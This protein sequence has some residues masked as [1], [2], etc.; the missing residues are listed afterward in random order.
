[1]LSLT[2]ALPPAP[3]RF[4]AAAALSTGSLAATAVG[5]LFAL[6]ARARLPLIMGFTAGVLIGLV[7]FDLMPEIIRLIG[8][9][10]YS[11]HRV[12]GAMAVGFLTFHAL[13]KLI[14]IHHH[15]DCEH[16]EHTHPRVGVLSALALAGHSFMDGV[17]IGLGFQVG[18]GVGLVVAVAVISHDFADGMNTVVVMLGSGNTPRKTL[19]YLA[20]GSLAPV[21]GAL[22]T[23]FLRPSPYVLALYLAFFA[24]FLLYIG[25]SHILPEAHS[26]RSSPWTLALTGMG[27]LFAFGVSVA[28]GS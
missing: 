2:V 26:K 3:A 22:A 18:W 6:R 13:E 12:M 10:G 24:G 11:P 8:A 20:L 16:E 19:P 17:S 9:G 28:A 14:V 25:A 7:C 1:M 4:L 5:G 23:F 21:L 27:A 15:G